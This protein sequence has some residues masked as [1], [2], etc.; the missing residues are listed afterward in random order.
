MLL[1]L[2]FLESSGCGGASG[3]SPSTPSHGAGEGAESPSPYEGPIRSTDVEL[4]ARRYA[5][6]CGNACHESGGGPPLANL[7]WSP[8]RMRRQIREGSGGMPAIPPS[9]LSDED[10]EALLAYL[11]TIGAVVVK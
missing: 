8:E 5:S 7:R 11:V 6:R 4:G 3:A 10:M 1:L 9:R 2:L